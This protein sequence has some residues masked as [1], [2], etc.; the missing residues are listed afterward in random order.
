M[1]DPLIVSINARLN[2]IARE[3]KK[4]FP[5]IKT[6]FLIERAVARLMKD[7]DLKK[8]LIFKGGYVGLRVYD[9]PRYTVDLDAIAHMKNHDEVVGLVKKVMEVDF[10]DGVW[11]KYEKEADLKHQN[12]YGGT[13][14]QY[15]GGIGKEI[16]KNLLKHQVVKIDIGTADPVVP[17]PVEEKF[18]EMIGEGE[19]SWKVYTRESILSE[20]IHALLTRGSESSRSKDVFDIVFHLKQANANILKEAIKR[21]FEYRKDEV[22]KNVHDKL[23]EINRTLLKNGWNSAVSSLESPPSFDECFDEMV[24]WFL[25]NKI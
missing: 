9:S 20:K 14:L 16:P 25:D 18:H 3:K 5:Y 21:T 12:D 4:K 11:F 15:R 13:Q 6:Q 23:T 24:R 22:P 19:L 10:G 8:S 2:N 1:E 17:Q 7:E